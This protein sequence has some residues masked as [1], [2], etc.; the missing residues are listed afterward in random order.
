V[1]QGGGAECLARLLLGQLVGG[2][3]AQLVVDQRQELAG[4]L[5][6]ARLDGGQDERYL[7]HRRHRGAGE[8]AQPKVAQSIPAAGKEG[9]DFLE[10]E[11]AQR[12]GFEAAISNGGRHAEV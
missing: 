7:S 12:F 5:E 11:N 4:G 10:R 9:A 8:V 3:P 2:E 1:G 6:V